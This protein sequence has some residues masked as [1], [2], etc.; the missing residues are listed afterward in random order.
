MYLILKL[1]QIL[2]LLR[3]KIRIELYK[4]SQPSPVRLEF[5]INYT[6]C[7]LAPNIK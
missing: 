5:F 7:N 6:A 3:V 4:P 2:H 1:K